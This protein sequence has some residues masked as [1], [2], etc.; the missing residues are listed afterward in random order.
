[1]SKTNI[2][3]DVVDLLIAKATPRTLSDQVDP[4]AERGGMSFTR[5]VTQFG[6]RAYVETGLENQRLAMEDVR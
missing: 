1:M 2:F 4:R 6:K 5:F 3:K